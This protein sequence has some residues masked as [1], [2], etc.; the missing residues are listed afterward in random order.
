MKKDPEGRN[1]I[2]LCLLNSSVD[3]LKAMDEL[4]KEDYVT[5]ELILE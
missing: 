5:D 3:V 1:I 2:V 4:F